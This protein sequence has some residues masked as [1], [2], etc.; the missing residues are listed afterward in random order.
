MK[1]FDFDK[2]YIQIAILA[3]IV[4]VFGTLF[5]QFLNNISIIFHNA[6]AT[7][8]FIM[9]LLRPFIIAFIIAYFLNPCVRFIESKQFV[10]KSSVLDTKQKKRSFSIFITYVIALAFLY[11]VISSIIPNVIRNINTLILALPESANEFRNMIDSYTLKDNNILTP[12]IETLNN[13]TNQNYTANNIVLSAVKEIGD[14]IFNLPQILASVVFGIVTFA[15]GIIAVILGF[16]ISIYMI[17]DKE[18]FLY[19]TKKI[20]YVIMKKQKAEK[21]FRVTNL[22][23]HI[24]ERFIIGKAIDSLIIGFMFFIICVLFKVPYAPLFG[25]IIGITNM[26]PYFGPFIG[27]IPVLIITLTWNYKMFLPIGLAILI[28]QQF[29]GIILGPKILGDS[30]GLKPISIIFAIIIGGGLFGVYGMFLG[31]P[32]Y[33]VLATIL[34]ELI[35]KNYEESKGEDIEG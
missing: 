25:L 19:H 27:A 15:N 28:L 22:S 11:L 31:A 16:V 20:V 29:D 26:I 21:L 5:E 4:I 33:A 12:A 6:K 35:N 1:K 3:I 7:F 18:Y 9:R 30:I 8:D 14:A 34:Q 2:K 23:N 13:L 17:A 10:K 32:V 24:L